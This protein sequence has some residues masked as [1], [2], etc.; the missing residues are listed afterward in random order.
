MASVQAKMMMFF[1]RKLKTRALRMMGD[2]ERLRKEKEKVF[3]RVKPP[4][5]VQISH[6][7]I[8]GIEAAHFIPKQNK[9][10]EKVVLYLHGG[11]YATGSIYSHSG[12]VAKL[13]LETG[14]VHV[15]INYR[16]A[17]EYPFPAGLD[18][19]LAAYDYLLYS[20]HY[21]AEDVIICG[22]SAGGGL[23]LSLIK[24]I[25]DTKRQDP[26]CS[27]VFSPWT[28][29]TVNGDSAISNPEKDPLLD[30]YYARIWANWYAGEVSLYDPYVSPLYGDL[31]NLPPILI[32]VGTEEI[33]FSDSISFAANAM[34]TNTEV[35]L[36]VYEEL[37]HVFQFCWQYLP[38]AKAAIGNVVNY[39]EK[40]IEASKFDEAENNTD[41]SNLSLMEKT[42]SFASL[43]AGAY[44]I[45]KAALR[46]KISGR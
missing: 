4:Q 14:I 18:D 29:L 19:A 27:I 16:L 42:I 33:L 5:D 12:F 37:P 3:S 32:Q 1:M 26:M 44:R 34:I 15:A 28:D 35:T 23:S 20:E 41:S 10:P 8:N 24:M 6:F 25:R 43:S 38:E 9:Y 36:D 39:I 22:D 46:K 13:A 17:P 2:L 21:K 31:N 30:V 45:G 7:E 11:G 40:Q